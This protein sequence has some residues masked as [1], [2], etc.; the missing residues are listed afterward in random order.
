M[1][2]A[3]MTPEEEF[4]AVYRE[5]FDELCDY[6]QRKFPRLGRN[7]DYA[8]VA[9]VAYVETLE[10]IRTEG[11]WP[12]TNWWNWLRWLAAHR[13]IDHLR[14]HEIASLEALATAAGESTGSGWQP[15][16]RGVPPSQVLAE[17]ERRGRQGITMSQILAEFCRWCESRPDGFKMQE[18]Y[19]RRMRGQIPADIAFSMRV[20]RN[21]VDATIKRAR[22]W[23]VNRV[24][25]ADVHRSV[26]VTMIGGK[27]EESPAGVPASAG[28][29]P[30]EAGTPA[31]QPISPAPELRSFD[32]VVRWVID[33]L[34][35]MCPSSE[36]LAVY[37]ERPDAVE[38]SDV[39]YHFA[40][41]GCKLCAAEMRDG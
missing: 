28:K 23:V 29:R 20:E 12:K 24:R 32:E 6:L 13:A 19:E 8:D 30:V 17:A 4:N 22:D 15:P 35:A 34:G 27:P 36:R 14:Q 10:K 7:D 2:G 9:Q 39:R 18:T 31:S 21:A 38:F 37:A 33:E 40:E 26:F 11:F 5:K 1:L 16:D 41:A 3:T 25:Q